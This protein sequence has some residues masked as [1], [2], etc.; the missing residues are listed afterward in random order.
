MLLPSVL[1]MCDVETSYIRAA[2]AI[3][4]LMASVAAS[5]DAEETRENLAAR[6]AEHGTL[7]QQ[8]SRLWLGTNGRLLLCKYAGWHACGCLRAACC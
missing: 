5:L 1:S 4:R 3:V 8:L 6:H 7:S 2:R